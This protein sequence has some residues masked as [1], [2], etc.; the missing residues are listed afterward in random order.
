VVDAADAVGVDADGGED[1]AGSG[2]GDRVG[3]GAGATAAETEGSA[4]ADG[5]DCCGAPLHDSSTGSTTTEERTSDGR[6]HT[7]LL[8]YA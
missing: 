3:A 2:T 8:Y 7:P 6:A 4:D 5:D 1:G